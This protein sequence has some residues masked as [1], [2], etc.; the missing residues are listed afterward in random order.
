MRGQSNHALLASAV[1]IE[2]ATV[3]GLLFGLPEGYPALIEGDGIV[4]G[5]LCFFE[6]LDAI[7]PEIDAYEGA[8]YA[9]VRCEATTEAGERHVAWCYA[10][11][12]APEEAWPIPSGRW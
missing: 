4:Y 2:P 3:R 9:R 10:A 8:L 5:E 11:D 6:D 1:R 7:L 12:R